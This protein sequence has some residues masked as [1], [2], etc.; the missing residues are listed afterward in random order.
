MFPERPGQEIQAKG[1]PDNKLTFP[2]I[3]GD[4]TASAPALISTILFSGNWF[5]QT[6]LLYFSLQ[7]APLG[8]A[9]IG[10]TTKDVWEQAQ[11]CVR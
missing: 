11:C 5:S 2:P 9:G 3:G 7:S 6:T 4:P 8:G 1:F 10:I